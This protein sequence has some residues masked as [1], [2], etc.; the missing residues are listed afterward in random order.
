MHEVRNKRVTVAGLGR[1]GGSIA[2]TR[3]LIEQGAARVV[4]T[5]RD[6]AEKLADSVAQLEGLPVELHLGGHRDED[7]TAADLVV[8]SP[9][10]PPA[11]PYLQMARAAG[12]PVTTEIRL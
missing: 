5:D 11:N 12:V 8:A 6:P 1:F 4:V 7:F 10:I 2:A 9:A 3:W